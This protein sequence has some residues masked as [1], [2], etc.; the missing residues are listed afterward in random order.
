MNTKPASAI[1]PRSPHISDGDWNIFEFL[2]DGRVN[3]ANSVLA[4]RTSRTLTT[5]RQLATVPEV[6]QWCHE[7]G[8]TLAP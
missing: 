8:S 1:P 4:P 5:P 6:L 7:E 2:S 3:A